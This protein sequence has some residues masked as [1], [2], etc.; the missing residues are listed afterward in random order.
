MVRFYCTSTCIHSLTWNG[1]G[2]IAILFPVVYFFVVLCGWLVLARC[3][4]EETGMAR[5]HNDGGVGRAPNITPKVKR[6]I[7]IKVCLWND[8]GSMIMVR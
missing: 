5:L 7:D 3:Y 1:I 2:C 8:H 6:V 4:N